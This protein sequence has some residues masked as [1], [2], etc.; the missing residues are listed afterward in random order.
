MVK[1]FEQSGYYGLILGGSSGLGLASAMKLARHGMGIVI[2][3]RSTRA[4]MKEINKSFDQI[5]ET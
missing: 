5:Q 1:E 2:I 3:H 4:Q